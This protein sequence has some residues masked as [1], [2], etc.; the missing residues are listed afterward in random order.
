MIQEDAANFQVQ[1]VHLFRVFEVNVAV[2]LKVDHEAK[3]EDWGVTLTS[4]DPQVHCV[5]SGPVKARKPRKKKDVL[6]G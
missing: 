1:L 5:S 2:G 6:S 3:E 4:V